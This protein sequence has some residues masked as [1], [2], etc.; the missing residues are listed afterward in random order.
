MKHSEILKKALGEGRHSLTLYE[1]LT[2][3]S[4]Y[5]L[6]VAKFVLA[7]TEEKLEEAFTTLSKPL[8]VKVSSP[9]V[10]HKTEIGGVKL[11]INT[12][13]ELKEAYSIILNSVRKFLPYARIEGVVVQE[14]VK[15]D[16]EVIIGGLNDAQFGPVVAFGLGGIMVEILN[17][18]AFDLAPLSKEEAYNLINRIKGAVI[19]RG[20][21]GKPPANLMKL[22]EVISKV[23]Y[24]IWDFRE[25]IKELDL[26]P[27][28]VSRDLIQVVDARFVLR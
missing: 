25:Y 9:D 28:M 27:V 14:M 13:K 18:V 21:R 5:K 4:A 16:Y 1:S 24:L 11:G 6:P 23:S 20:Y 10:T 17:D 26:N 15:G 7:D 19:L 3:I 2:L 22:A 12:L 8:V